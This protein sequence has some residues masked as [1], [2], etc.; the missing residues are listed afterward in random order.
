MAASV[1][2]AAEIAYHA[3]SLPIFDLF[4]VTPPVLLPRTHLVGRGPAERRLQE[5]LG[6]PDEDLLQPYAD[7]PAEEV[8]QAA[9][10]ESLGQATAGRLAELVPALERLDPTLTGALENATKKVVHQFEQL[11]ERARK[12]A[13]RR[14]DVAA[15]RRR[16]LEKTLLPSVGGVPA[17]RVYP[18]LCPMLAFGREPVLAA[19]RSV[20]GT[21]AAGVA[22]VDFGTD[23]GGPHAG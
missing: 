12:A 19:L 14:T 7:A 6:I 5:Q 2:G 15:G 1:L 21:G 10:L 16:R 22:V 13:E 17:E 11:A 4:E 9:A 8:P 18:P 20:A 23:E 3:Q